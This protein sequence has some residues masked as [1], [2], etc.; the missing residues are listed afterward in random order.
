MI[1]AVFRAAVDLSQSHDRNFEFAGQELQPTGK[2]SHLLLSAITAIIRLDELQVIDEHHA[3]LVTQFQTAGIG[4]DTQHALTGRVVDEDL[5]FA[6]LIAG[7]DQPLHVLA[8][9]PAHPE[10]MAIDLGLTTKQTLGQLDAR[11]LKTHKKDR[12]A[13]LHADVAHEVEGKRC[14]AGTRS[15]GNDDEFRVLQAGGDVVQVGE[16][17]LQAADGFV[18]A[19][20]AGVDPSIGFIERGLQREGLAGD[21]HLRDVENLAFGR[22]EQLV[23]GHRLIVGVAQNFVARV[24]QIANDGFVADDVRVVFG[25]GGRRR[26]IPQFGQV[27]VA[28][29]VVELLAL[30]TGRPAERGQRAGPCRRVG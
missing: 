18:A 12:M 3:N 22:F 13:H 4:C 6:Q 19:F 11:L 24:D 20:V 25:V 29:D 9:Q 8:A 30:S 7:F 17:C 1:L 28:A 5:G 14:L 10:L 21:A 23:G 27:S 26:G 15:G 2:L 16:S